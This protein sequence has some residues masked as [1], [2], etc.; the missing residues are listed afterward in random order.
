MT[1]TTA[2]APL[3]KAVVVDCSVERA[4]EVFT[5]RLG[6]WWPL[7]THSVAAPPPSGST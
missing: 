2:L 3:T 5:D 7:A 1:E 6:E 4:F